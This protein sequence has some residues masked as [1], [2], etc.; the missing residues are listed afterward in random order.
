MTAAVRQVP[1]LARVCAVECRSP[2]R[3]EINLWAGQISVSGT[4]ATGSRTITRSPS[5]GEESTMAAPGG[6]FRSARTV[7]PAPRLSSVPCPFFSVICDDLV[8]EARPAPGYPVHDP[9]RYATKRLLD[10]KAVDC[11]FWISS[12]GQRW[13]HECAER[14]ELAE[15]LPAPHELRPHPAARGARRSHRHPGPRGAA[16]ATIPRGELPSPADFLALGRFRLRH[17]HRHVLGISGLQLSRRGSRKP[18]MDE[19]DRVLRSHRGD[20]CVKRLV[21]FEESV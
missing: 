8:V 20:R 12:L 10:A 11:L 17:C 21:P 13:R 18:R 9:R 14:H 1:P 5:G 19:R 3:N 7:G 6:G 16:A 15:R 2:H 4:P